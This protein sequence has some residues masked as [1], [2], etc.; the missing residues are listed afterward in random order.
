MLK[1]VWNQSKG[2]S[3]G[4]LTGKEL[5]QKSIMHKKRG[6]QNLLK[7]SLCVSSRSVN[8]RISFI[9][10]SFH[11]PT[12]FSNFPFCLRQ[13]Q[14]KPLHRSLRVYSTFLTATISD[15]ASNYMG[16]GQLLC[17]P[18]LFSRRI[19]SHFLESTIAI[20]VVMW[21]NCNFLIPPITP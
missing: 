17:R 5:A 15:P 16:Q 19:W 18:P 14:I 12:I 3:F 7:V 2:S 4:D 20:L 13:P 10:S 8:F 21:H 9:L 6:K 11:F 1:L